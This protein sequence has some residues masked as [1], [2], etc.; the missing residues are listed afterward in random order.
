MEPGIASHLTNSFCVRLPQGVCLPVLPGDI[1]D[2]FHA[3]SLVRFILRPNHPCRSASCPTSPDHK[4]QTPRTSLYY[5]FGLIRLSFLPPSPCS[6]VECI[7]FGRG[8]G[9]VSSR[10]DRVRQR[11]RR[12]GTGQSRARHHCRLMWHFT[13]HTSPIAE[14]LVRCQAE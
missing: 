13:R 9:F 3:L 7:F 6:G 11:D 8:E 2:S 10:I 5:M 14:D 1:A 12:P 4:H